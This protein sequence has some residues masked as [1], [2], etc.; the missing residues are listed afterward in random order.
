MP[1]QLI[2]RDA[3]VTRLVLALAGDKA[4]P[5]AYGCVS[6]ANTRA[7]TPVGTPWLCSFSERSRLFFTVAS[8]PKRDRGLACAVA[9][10]RTAPGCSAAGAELLIAYLDK[11]CA[12]FSRTPFHSNDV[13]NARQRPPA[14]SLHRPRPRPHM[15]CAL[16]SSWRKSPRAVTN[17]SLG[18]SPLH[19]SSVRWRASL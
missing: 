18:S 16:E 6:G 4:D 7:S 5:T 19:A 8:R 10:P 1:L 17:Y 14:L 13:D 12:L 15:L 11:K 9:N 3:S 2:P